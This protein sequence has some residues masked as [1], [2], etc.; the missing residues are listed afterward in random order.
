[1]LP[2]LQLESYF[3]PQIKVVAQNDF[4]QNE[5]EETC[6]DLNVQKAIAETAVN[7]TYQVGINIKV[8]NAEDKV[9]PYEISLEAV[10]TFILAPEISKEKKEKLLEINGCSMLYGMCREFLM[11]VTSRGP[12]KGFMLPT[13]SFYTPPEEEEK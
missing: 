6:F 2:P 10:G 3:F 8:T 13:V 11:S 9:A 4:Q 1:M 12:W 7:D 5:K